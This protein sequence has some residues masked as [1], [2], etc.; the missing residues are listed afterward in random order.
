MKMKFISIL[1]LLLPLFIFAQQNKPKTPEEVVSLIKKNVTC[2]W[3]TQTVDNFK[4]GD[5]NS[6]LK[7]IAV[8]MFADMN[9]LKTAVEKGCNFIIT[10]EPVFYNHMD[11][12]SSF[13]N[14]PVYNEK[15]KYIKDNNLV[16]LR[17]HDHIHMT[18]PDGISV[19]MVDKLGLK[20]YSVNGS[21]TYFKV[22]EKTVARY[23]KELKKKFDMESVRTIGNPD[24][25][26]TKVAFMAGAPGGQRHIQMLQNPDVEVIIAGEA[27]E[28][29]TYLYTNDAVALGKSKA[30]IF[31]G[32]I[33]SEEAGMKYCAEWLETFITGV[34]IH[35]IENK[36]N[37]ITF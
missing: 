32:H 16:I 10:H 13:A 17:F 5:P 36:A 22:P 18:K 7:G 9:T 2:D 20:E 1:C 21:L 6:T 35:F 28:W 3:A 37:F 15:A 29:E 31:L 33:K 8:C 27:P 12:T 26:F 14:D 25:K 23:A 24:M 4:A 11:E 34:P 19:G 30:V